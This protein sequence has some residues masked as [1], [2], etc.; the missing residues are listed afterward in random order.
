MKSWVLVWTYYNIS[1]D[2]YH[3]VFAEH[4]LFTALA[5]WLYNTN[6]VVCN[7]TDVL[8]AKYANNHLVIEIKS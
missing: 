8:P 2:L 5:M 1:V 6:H 7:T 3:Y 4:C